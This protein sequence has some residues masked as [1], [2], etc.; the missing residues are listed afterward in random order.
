MPILSFICLLFLWKCRIHWNIFTARKRS[1]WKMFLHLS[2]ILFTGVSS[3]GVSVE[4]FS[5]QG[6]SLS[7]GISVRG[8][9][10]NVFLFHFAFLIFLIYTLSFMI[11]S[12]I[13][14]RRDGYECTHFRK[15]PQVKAKIPPENLV[16]LP[17]NRQEPINRVFH[18]F[19][20]TT[21]IQLSKMDRAYKE[22]SDYTW[23]IV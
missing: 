8:S 2:V 18:Q 13:T 9:Y 3:R 19:N 22:K 1:C 11:W 20:C 5:V 6:W 17:F 12:H 7:R 10:W 16:K 14:Q 4:G 21:M 15:Q 23:S